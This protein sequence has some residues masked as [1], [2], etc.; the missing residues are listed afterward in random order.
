MRWP[1]KGHGPG[2]R[3][4]SR[5]WLLV[6]IASSALPLAGNGWL[7]DG[8]WMTWT[9]RSFLPA[10]A[11][12]AVLAG[13]LASAMGLVLLA[14]LRLSERERRGS[15]G[16]VFSCLLVHLWQGAR[17][18][19][20]EG[21]EEP[22]VLRDPDAWKAVGSTVALGV[23]AS[24]LADGLLVGNPGRAALGG[25]MAVLFAWLAYAFVPRAL[26]IRPR[27]DRVARQ[28]ARGMVVPL[29]AYGP[30]RGYSAEAFLA[31][32]EAWDWDEA[33]RRFDTFPDGEWYTSNLRPLLH[34]INEHVDDLRYLVLLR[35]TMAGDEASHN[36]QRVEEWLHRTLAEKT[37]GRLSIRMAGPVDGRSFTGVY[38]AVNDAV[39]RMLDTARREGVHLLH[40]DIVIDVTGGLT[41]TSVAA[42]AGS[43][44]N[45]A[46][47]QYVDTN[48]LTRG[49]ADALRCYDIGLRGD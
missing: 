46:R 41:P 17:R 29:S 30:P 23:A 14:A 11:P 25:A 48:A 37:A 4:S 9:E 31:K 42:A 1:G 35:P 47:F 34:G 28:P 39:A 15:I 8:L 49:E 43:L 18:E 22:P 20:T 7:A 33:T 16:H 45:D 5:T 32:L 38:S 27:L 12:W 3:R 19:T 26:P 13:L 44:H 21:E 6:V 10:D 2:T 24:W 40:D 36:Q